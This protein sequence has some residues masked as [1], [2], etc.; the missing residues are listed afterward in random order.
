M[1]S[2]EMKINEVH[3]NVEMKRKS[4]AILPVKSLVLSMRRY[5]YT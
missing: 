3:E 2:A 5:L 1:M 4:P